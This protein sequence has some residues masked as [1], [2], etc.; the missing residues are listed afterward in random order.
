VRNPVFSIHTKMSISIRHVFDSSVRQG[1][2]LK[3][4]TIWDLR[5]H[6]GG[7]RVEIG[8]MKFT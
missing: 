6:A 4:M 7:I 8:H 1:D 3:Y 5:N 2:K